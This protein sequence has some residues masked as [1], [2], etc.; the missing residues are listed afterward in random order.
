MRLFEITTTDPPDTAKFR[1][2]FG[3]SKV[4]DQRGNPLLVYHGTKKRFTEFDPA[5]IKSG[6]GFWFTSNEAEATGHSQGINSRGQT[7][8]GRVIKAYLS[9][10]NPAMD[11]EEHQRGTDSNRRPYDGYIHLDTGLYVAYRPEQ[12]WVVGT[13][14]ANPAYLARV[15]S[16]HR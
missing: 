5:K 2:W 11:V 1:R 16:N 4:V 13:E 6:V 7:V 15:W 8:R 9:L 10:Q 14:E 12:I 3:Q